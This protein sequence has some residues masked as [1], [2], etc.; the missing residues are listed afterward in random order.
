[1]KSYFPAPGYPIYAAIINKLDARARYYNL[2]QKNNWQPSLDEI[3]SLINQRTRAI[4]LINPSNPTGAITPDETTKRLL[5][6]PQN[7]IYS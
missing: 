5:D 4:I 6:S 7:T 1:M 2:D 3:R